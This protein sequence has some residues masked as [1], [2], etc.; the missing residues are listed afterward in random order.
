MTLSRRLLYLLYFAATSC[1]LLATLALYYVNDNLVDS[2]AERNAG[3]ELD[4]VEA[5]FLDQ[6]SI[7]RVRAADWS[8]RQ[9][10]L[11]LSQDGIGQLDLL[12]E[13]RD[14]RVNIRRG[15]VSADNP[16]LV[17]LASHFV[18]GYCLPTWG[19]V[20]VGKR[21]LLFSTA[22]EQGCHAYLVGVWINTQ[23]LNYLSSRVGHALYLQPLEQGQSTERGLYRQDDGQWRGRFPLPDYLGGSPMEMLVDLPSDGSN[24]VLHAVLTMAVI[25]LL[26]SWGAVL[27]INRRIKSILFGRVQYLHHAVRSIAR[28]GE[29]NQRV[30]VE[31]RDEISLLAEDFNTMVDNIDHTQ[32]QLA[33]ARRQAEVAS[34]AKSQFLANISHEIRTP[35]TA[36]LGY[37][38]LLRDGALSS[39]EQARYLNIIQNNGDALLA[40]INDVLDLSR[41]EAGQLSLEQRVFTIAELMDEVVASHRLL[42]REKQVALS[43]TLDDSVPVSVSGDVFRLRQI[44]MNLIGNAV[45]FTEQGSVEVQVG[46]QSSASQL[47]VRVADTGIGMNERQLSRIFQPFSQ[48]D[49]THSRRY[50]GTGL[51]LSIARQ[52]ARSQ[53]GDITVT[54]QEEVG[55][56][57]VLTLPLARACQ[58]ELAPEPETAVAHEKGPRLQ[59]RVLLVEDNTVNRLFV[60]KVLEQAGMTVIEAADGRDACEQHGRHRALDLVVLDMQ[61]PVMDGYQTVQAL[62]DRGFDGPV[63]ALTA[64]VLAEDRQRCLEAG[65]DEFLGKPVR[66]RDLLDICARLL[67]QPRAASADF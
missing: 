45:K 21:S 34:Q 48:V 22:V 41:I 55:S 59:G 40:L 26:L 6:L 64:N 37:T 52:L 36:I 65:C 62:R 57:F 44:L 61:M 54:S 1:A 50:T 9:Q 42:A 39:L 60:R 10:A 23:W 46:W 5:A 66:V 33:S 11:P 67:V 38:E 8:N 32:N 24:A 12:A 4:K 30:P 49:A 17:A 14:D 58:V 56:C 28:G 13:I 25:M 51:G 3:R 63:L 20:R 29:L 35:M 47:E 31:G 2:L 53:G 19:V 43:L 15:D 18:E 27:F 7:L 16:A